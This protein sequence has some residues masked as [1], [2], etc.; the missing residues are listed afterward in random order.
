ML[1]TRQLD[2]AKL[3]TATKY[4]SIETYHLLGERGVL[5]SPF[6]Q[7]GD[8]Q[9]IV[10][11]K[12][13]GTNVRVILM[14]DDTVLIGSREHFLH[15]VGDLVPNPA[16]QIVE[17]V[18]SLA[19][20]LPFLL[21]QVPDDSNKVRILYLEVFG[22]NVGSQARQYT[23]NKTRTAYRLFDAATLDITDLPGMTLEEVAG[24]RDHGDALQFVPDNDLD[25]LAY[26]IR[27]DR[28]PVLWR[29]DADKLPTTRTAMYDQIGW[30]TG[31][32]TRVLLDA[33]GK[34]RPEGVVLRTPDRSVI[35]KARREDY[36]RTFRA[37]NINPDTDT[38]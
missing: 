37:L 14:P 19:T 1:R 31:P 24:W 18:L 29:G 35:V 13:D 3:N 26:L 9:V 33:G 25:E 12:I 30:W 2:L 15:A 32:T 20:K 23:D 21:T 10:T 8:Q 17:S 36:T 34:G 28:V 22:G 5:Q 16:Q 7:F 4:P 6:V 38:L 27:V 11:E